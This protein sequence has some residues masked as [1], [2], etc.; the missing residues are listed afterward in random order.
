MF[1]NKNSVIFGC[2]S[3][4]V[5][6]ATFLFEI[7]S[8]MYVLLRYRLSY[9]LR[10]IT[11]LLRNLSIFQLAEYFVCDKSTVAELYSRIGFL[12]ITVL[13]VLGLHLMVKISKFHI[14][15]K[16]IVLYLLALSIG[17]YFLL[18]PNSFKAYECTGNYVI[19]Q[20]GHMQA[21]L[22]SIYYFGV[23]AVTVGIGLLQLRK[24]NILI[25][26]NILWLIAGYAVF[27]IPVAI[28]TITH[29]DSRQAI[30]SILCGF[31]VLFAVV[32]VTKVCRGVLKK[33]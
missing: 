16:V 24:A 28:L 14:K 12:A 3:P 4:P 8:V 33:R 26:R 7:G 13:P 11:A 15:M 32:L 18:A 6:I 31:A 19:F 1:K 17:I 10:I 30:P 9:E 2:F 27:I 20:I 23:I 21:W 5:M 29:P 25:K 22:Y